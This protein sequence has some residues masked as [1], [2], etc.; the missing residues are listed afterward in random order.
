MGWLSNLLFGESKEYRIVGHLRS[1]G[2]ETI[3]KGTDY[4]NVSD[5]MPNRDEPDDRYGRVQLYENGVLVED[6]YPPR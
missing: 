6:V 4:S 1:G 3:Y 5:M 2:N